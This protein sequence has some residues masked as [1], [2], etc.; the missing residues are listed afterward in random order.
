MR[1]YGGTFPSQ[2]E[3]SEAQACEE[4]AEGGL[5]KTV[6]LKRGSLQMPMCPVMAHSDRRSDVQ[7]QA[8]RR[9]QWPLGE[10]CP[11]EPFLSPIRMTIQLGTCDSR[12]SGKWKIFNDTAY[13]VP[14]G[15]RLL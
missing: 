8:A 11:F 7:G 14:L 4:P 9:Q 3:M 13:I 10:F 6:I 12:E 15:L 1:D 5:A 2:A